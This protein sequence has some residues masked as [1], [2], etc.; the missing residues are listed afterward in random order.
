MLASRV[1]TCTHSII[2]LFALLLFQGFPSWA[3]VKNV[4]ASDFT[5]A[6]DKGDM[7]VPSAAPIVIA[8]SITRTTKVE[9]I[10]GAEK[11]L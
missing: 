7:P 11:N 4:N 10:E 6:E 5:V 9:K 2:S 8:V 1:S 3:I